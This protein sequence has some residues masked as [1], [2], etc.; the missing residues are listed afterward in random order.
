MF[1]RETLRGENTRLLQKQNFSDEKLR[2]EIGQLQASLIN[3][4]EQIPF[5]NLEK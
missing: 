3:K 4:E 5:L 2:D 1:F